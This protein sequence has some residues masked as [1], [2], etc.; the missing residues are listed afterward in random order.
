MTTDTTPEHQPSA[1][2][3][4]PEEQPTPDPKPAS[5]SSR[6][7]RLRRQ[8]IGPF[9]VAQVG[10]VVFAIVFSAVALVVLTSPLAVPPPNQPQ[11][12]STAFLVGS[13]E[14]GMRVGDLAPEFVG[15]TIGGQTV[16]LTD[17]DG[18]PVRL[19]DLRG[20]PVWVNFW[21]SWCAP[22]QAET[23]ILREMY[24][25]YAS[26][27][28]A[29]VAISVQE[30]TVDDVR[31]YV[32]KYQLDYT[33]GFDATSAIFHAYHAFALP[34]Q[35]FVDKDGVIRNVQLGPVTR[36]QADRVISSLFAG[37][38]IAPPASPGPSPA[39]TPAAQSE[40]DPFPR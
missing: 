12:G 36:D 5:K 25:K 23:P 1:P 21:A 18:N 9:T 40:I 38:T 11:P 14:P 7:D 22:C 27:G 31:A 33:V 26:Q 13:P 32:D 37:E 17:L 35:I 20:R 15:T 19:A 3:A 28:L 34:T 30:S 24:D 6:D 16:Q 8:L 4:T 29:L 39:A 2:D 10:A